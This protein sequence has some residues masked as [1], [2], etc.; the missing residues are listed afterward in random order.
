MTHVIMID[1]NGLIERACGA[2]LRVCYITIKTLTL[3]ISDI[4]L[5]SC[6]YR[7]KKPTI[8][9]LNMFHNKINLL[10]Q[11]GSRKINLYTLFPYPAGV[12]PCCCGVG[13]EVFI[14]VSINYSNPME[15][16]IFPHQD[17]RC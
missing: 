5:D 3:A 17:V 9:T 2:I 13:I 11:A 16:E 8:I 14:R 10:P 15:I 1:I 4:T 7:D 12:Q 6:V